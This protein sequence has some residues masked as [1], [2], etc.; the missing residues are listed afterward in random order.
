[1]VVHF[2]NRNRRQHVNHINN[3]KKKVAL[4]RNGI[5]PKLQK[6]SILSNIWEIIYFIVMKIEVGKIE[7][8]I[9]QIKKLIE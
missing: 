6:L 7:N 3:N 5:I 2:L 8:L 1:M 4:I 9:N